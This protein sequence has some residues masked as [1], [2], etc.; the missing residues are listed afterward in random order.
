MECQRQPAAATDAGKLS[1]MHP[2]VYVYIQIHNPQNMHIHAICTLTWAAS[3]WVC[4]GSLLLLPSPQRIASTPAV[5][6][7][8]TLDLE[9]EDDAD[10]LPGRPALVLGALV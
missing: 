1:H 6:E 7:R 8:F 5:S 10:Q 4:A 9:T 3:V 2:N